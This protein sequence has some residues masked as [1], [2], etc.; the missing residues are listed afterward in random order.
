MWPLAN[1]KCMANFF[2]NSYNLFYGLTGIGINRYTIPMMGYFP[3]TRK[4]RSVLS[5]FVHLSTLTNKSG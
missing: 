2:Y 5:V 1:N 4:Y 3:F